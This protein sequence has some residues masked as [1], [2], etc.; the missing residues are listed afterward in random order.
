M[1][2]KFIPMTTATGMG[3]L[4]EMVER[5]AGWNAVVGL[6][7]Q[8]HLPLAIIDDRH[9]RLPLASLI[10]LFENAGRKMGDRTFG[11]RVGEQ[12]TLKSFGLWGRYAGSASYMA[13]GLRRAQ[14]MIW[15]HQSGGRM[16]VAE[17]GRYFI[18]R[19][20]NPLPP[21]LRG[22][23]HSDHLIMPMVA[24]VRSF[25]GP[26]WRPDWVELDYPKDRSAAE[27]EDRSGSPFGSTLRPWGLR[28]PARERVRSSRQTRTWATSSMSLRT[29]FWKVGQ[30]STISEFGQPQK[31]DLL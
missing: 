18:F 10:D 24:L 20:H 25:L 5:A 9:V 2:L 16:S 31:L 4:P 3:S 12:M 8:Q 11:L 21:K 14:Q 1:S 30:S 7:S 26:S 27:L 22:S 19:Y 17:H 6:F 23:Q 15:A 28:F 29:A 13:E